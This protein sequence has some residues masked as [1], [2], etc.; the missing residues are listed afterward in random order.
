MAGAAFLGSGAGALLATRAD[1][2]VL[3]P[4]VLV[5]LVAVLAYTLRTPGLGEVERLEFQH[6]V[7]DPEPLRLARFADVRDELRADLGL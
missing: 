5:A 7:L 2:D 1:G 3:K 4:V 6:L